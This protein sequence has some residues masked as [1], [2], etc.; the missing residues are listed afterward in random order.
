MKQK[1]TFLLIFLTLVM[2]ACE[3]ETTQESHNSPP[4]TPPLFTLLSSGETGVDFQNTLTEG[5]NTNILMYE[6]FYNGG[7]VAT[8]DLN[9]DGLIDIYFSA[10]MSDNKLYLN[11]GN[12]KFVD[13]TEASKAGGNPGPWKTGVTMADV[14]G[15]GKL[16]IYLSYSGTMPEPKRANQLFINQG[17]DENNIPIFEEQAAQWKINSP[18][19][20][21]QAYFFDFDRD[22]DLDMLL[23]N[24]NPKS[25][26]VLNEVN[27][28]EFLS[29]DDP[30]RGVRLFEQ[31]N[32]AFEDITQKAGIVGSGLSYGLGIGITDIN[33]DGWADFYISNDYTVPD[34][35]Y[36]NNQNGTFTNQLNQSVGHNSHF[37][38]GNDIADFNNDGW[39]D[40]ITLDMLP[41][42]NH[43]Q[44]I[45]LSPD[46]YAKFN[47]NIRSGFH[48]QYMRNMLQMNNGDGTFS[49]VGQLMG[50]SNTDWSWAALLADYNNDGWKDLFVT[51][52]YYR[53]YT[54]LDFIKYM[55]DFTK[56]KGRLQREDV[57]EIISH[58]PASD[59][60]NYIFANENGNGFTNQ[61]LN[62][63]FNQPAN[64]N[65]AAYADLDND[66]DLDLVINNINQPAFVYR[67]DADQRN[68]NH[69]L[70]VALKGDKLNTYGI[71][72]K[73]TL[74]HQGEKQTLE[75]YP[76]RGYLSSVSPVLHFGLGNKTKID[77]LEVVWAS[78]KTQILTNIE[79]DQELC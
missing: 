14:N 63:G 50:I 27:T 30:F 36:V 55:N 57:L 25:L 16:D 5:L 21:N 72:A 12:M 52:G 45:L 75:Q 24:H 79:T 26:P 23:L 33:R 42:D 51:N 8:G 6:Y 68:E 35:L 19:F 67:N 54:N 18:A 66:G 60:K 56:A 13:A 64:S 62:W 69:Y 28:K 43:R 4:A 76:S 2:F 11:Q 58:M 1:T 48:Y 53:D 73:I 31:K 37:S 71:G 34:Y 41:E 22:G 47:L 49:E 65:G 78:G 40:I 74:I 46:N 17:N 15:D 32:Q 70:K 39:Q 9:G 7:G 61:T 38:M 3:N 77:S 10:N 20:S 59:V 44:K 29:Q